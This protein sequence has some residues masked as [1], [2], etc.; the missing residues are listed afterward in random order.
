MKA[1]TLRTRLALALAVAGLAG[2]AWCAEPDPVAVGRA[3]YLEGRLPSGEPL[4]GVRDGATAVVGREAACVLCH[5]RSGMGASEG[6]I[7]VPPIIAPALYERFRRPGE[8]EPRRAA[9]VGFRDFPFR[10]RKPYDATSLAVAMREGVDTE[11]RR[12]HYLM[13]RY[14]LGDAEMAA[15]KAY[16][17]TL[18][19]GPSAGVDLGGRV[20][21]ATVV[22]PDADPAQRNVF[23]QTLRAC[24]A[25]KRPSR[26]GPAGETSWV[27]HEW[28]LQGPASG[29]EQ[30]LR[31][32]YEGQPVF[33]MVSGLGRDEWGPVHRFCDAQRLPCLLPNVDL[34]GD[35]TEGVYN[36]YLSRGVALEAAVVASHLGEETLQ[37]PLRRVVQLHRGEGAGAA[38][39]AD[40]RT[41]LAGGAVQ[42]EDR[43]LDNAALAPAQ[44]TQARLFADLGPGDAL[45][46]WLRTED[47]ARLMRRAPLPPA[48]AVVFASGQLGGLESIPLNAAWRR[49]TRLLWPVDAPGRWSQRAAF[50][51]H[52][53]LTRLRV[54]PADER[55]QGNTL[56]AC[57]VLAESLYRTQGV[58]LR[59]HVIELI[60]SAASTM[61]NAA[62]TAAFPRFVLG[63]DQRYASKGAYILRFGNTARRQLEPESDWIVP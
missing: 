23:L 30:Q 7:T 16:M 36:F 22:T 58:L 42:V 56:T 15:L 48:G 27:L 10:T 37:P 32:A 2:A 34:P 52:P 54:A 51:L 21:L 46:L 29:W 19:A 43:V 50:N 8:R 12:F 59:E 11:G 6:Q 3:L 20:H 62:A 55:L 14:E 49:P 45:V 18:G 5:R 35:A 63:T 9:G 17:D 31:A 28:T 57:A 47:V 33:A 53:W 38:A 41:A 24:V 60:E 61:G 4:R 25:D 44:G 1:H 26:T 40:L 13:P 39:A